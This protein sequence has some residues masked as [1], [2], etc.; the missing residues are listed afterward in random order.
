MT[1]FDLSEQL[2]ER[3]ASMNILVGA[4][5]SWVVWLY[6]DDPSIL[7]TAEDDDLETAVREALAE[8]DQTDSDVT[9]AASQEPN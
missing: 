2:D 9:T 5:P 3:R 4:G 6:A 7:F 1:L 8:W